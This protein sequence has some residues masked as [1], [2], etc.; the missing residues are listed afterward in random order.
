MLIGHIYSTLGPLD[1]GVIHVGGLPKTPKPPLYHQVLFSPRDLVDEYLRPARCI[2]NGE[3]ITLNPL[4]KIESIQIG[5]FTLERFP[6]D[7][8]R[9]LLKT[10]R[11]KNLIE[12]TLR[13]PG[14]LERMRVL[15]E[16]GFFKEE[17]IDLTLKVILPLM[18]YD[19]QDISIMKVYG[20]AG[21]TVIKFYTYDEGQG[22]FTSMACMTG[23][24]TALISRLIAKGRVEQGIIPPE[25]L[26]M[27]SE[28]LNYILE[29]LRARGVVI[30]VSRE[31]I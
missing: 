26:G 7:G 19:S 25:Y 28:I 29:E 4:D 9:T 6:T 2:V 3:L 17:Y 23:F 12:Y 14:H 15:K 16:L 8:L 10:I 11:A 31:D 21:N 13:W 20:R 30:Q 5:G 1:E 24:M 27:R 22:G 18:H